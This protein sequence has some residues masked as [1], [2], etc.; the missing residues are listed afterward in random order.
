[1]PTSSRA[2][3]SRGQM[4]VT[5]SRAISRAQSVARCSAQSSISPHP[6][7]RAGEE[8]VRRHVAHERQQL[9]NKLPEWAD[10]AVAQ[11]EKGEL[12]SF[13]LI[14]PIEVGLDVDHALV[15]RQGRL[16]AHGMARRKAA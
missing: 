16:A 1:M 9:L 15:D 3:S 5:S 4:P 8:T 10:P 2:A 6:S 7:R 13:V 12:T 11:R 14:E